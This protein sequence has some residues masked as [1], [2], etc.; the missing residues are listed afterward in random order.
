MN[1]NSTISVLDL[2]KL[3]KNA[4]V[5]LIDVRSPMEYH[6]I[7]APAAKNVPLAKLDPKKMMAARD[8]AADKPIYV[9]CK[10]GTRGAS[11]QQ[12]FFDAGFTNVVNVEGGTDAWLSAGLP[13][14]RGKQAI[15]LER[16]VRIAAG[17]IVFIG[18][19]LAII[20]HPNWAIIPAFVGLGLMFAGITNWCGMG[21]LLARMPWNQVKTTEACCNVK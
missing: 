8:N 18:A 7:H 19:L 12:R 14:V 10:S 3:D 1:T 9:I 20:I 13:V 4:A 21:L 16:Q 15:S 2:G 11:A 5:D 17:L 6:E